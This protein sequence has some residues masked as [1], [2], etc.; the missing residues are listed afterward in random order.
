[1]WCFLGAVYEGEKMGFTDIFKIKEFKAEIEQLRQENQSLLSKNETAHKQLS[2]LGAFDYYEIKEKTMRLENDFIEK[3][4]QLKSDYSL[5]TQSAENEFKKTIS[6][7]ERMTS[8]R[9][10]KCQQILEQLNELRLQEAK[11]NKSVK[12]QTNKLNRSKELVKAIN[13][14]FDKYLNY[15]PSQSI[16]RFPDDKLQELEE[17]S[18]SVILKLH[19]MDV[20]D[21]RK[22]YRDNDKQIDTILK[23]YSARYTTKANQAIYKLMVIALRAELQ[24]VLYN[25]KYEKLDKSVEDI[26]S[27]TRKYLKIA[28][29]GN[30][31]IAGTLAKFIG[32]IEYLF[33]NAV[34]IEY[35]Y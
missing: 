35:N 4:K 2:D 10:A 1:M 31:S 14:T 3:E 5:K 6:D 24:N 26:K 19:C 30:Q 20:K 23:K 22:A 7:F 27:V 21:L 13:Y 18:P 28:G 11:I 33:I 32:E 8:D 29:E 12:T 25:L 17:I 9:S 15:E 16:L 34:K